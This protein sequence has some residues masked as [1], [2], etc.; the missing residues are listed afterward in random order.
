M[1]SGR[2]QRCVL[3]SIEVD[4]LSSQRIMGFI[5]ITHKS[6]RSENPVT[7]WSAD[8]DIKLKTCAL[9]QILDEF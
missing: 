4:I 1:F 8:R 7:W 3:C 2:D 6:T 9:W 5:L